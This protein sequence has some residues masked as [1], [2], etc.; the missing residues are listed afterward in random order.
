MEKNTG[1]NH[2]RKIYLKKKIESSSSGNRTLRGNQD[3][4]KNGLIKKERFQSG[5]NNYRTPNMALLEDFRRRGKLTLGIIGI[6]L[7]EK[8]TQ[9]TGSVIYR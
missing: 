1:V 5:T 8:C 6:S 7:C 3:H 9:N 4:Q 2:W